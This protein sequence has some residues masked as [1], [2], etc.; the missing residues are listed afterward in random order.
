MDAAALAGFVLIRSSMNY[1]AEKVVE[2][3]G[4]NAI[5]VAN[6][7]RKHQQGA[8]QKLTAPSG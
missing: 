4:F 2:K 7:G 1:S 3:G 5:K 8:Q 6:Q